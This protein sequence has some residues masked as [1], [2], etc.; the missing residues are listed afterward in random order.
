MMRRLV[1]TALPAVALLCGAPGGG[2]SPASAHDFY[3]FACCSDRDC[4]P[5][6]FDDVQVT[7][8]GYRI[9]ATGIVIPFADHRI[10]MTPVEDHQQRY[11]LCTTS[12]TKTGHVL[13]LYVPQGGV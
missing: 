2:P 8:R 12:G 10:R 1:W 9:E 13:C 4:R 7:P 3:D 5:I 6:S 11:H